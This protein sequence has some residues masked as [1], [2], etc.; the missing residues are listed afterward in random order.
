MFH[1]P[2]LRTYL[3]LKI[4][5]TGRGSEAGCDMFHLPHLKTYLY[6]K[7][8]KHM[9]IHER[10]RAASITVTETSCGFVDGVARGA[11]VHGVASF[12]IDNAS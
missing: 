1:L 8:E 3:Y 4:E 5:N 7:I 2:H 10:K 6:L 12:G 11:Q 9:S